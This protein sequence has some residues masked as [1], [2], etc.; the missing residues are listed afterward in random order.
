VSGI[1]VGLGSL[2]GCLLGFFIPNV[3]VMTLE[4]R[5]VLTTGFLIDHDWPSLVTLA[6]VVAGGR[7]GYLG[8]GALVDRQK[9]RKEP[10]H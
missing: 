2:I 3:I 1:V 6:L 8:V 4:K 5:G 7:L 10:S 9:T